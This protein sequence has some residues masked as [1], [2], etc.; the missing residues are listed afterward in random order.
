MSKTTDNV[1][2]LAGRAQPA[3][4]VAYTL[5]NA[6]PVQCTIIGDEPLFFMSYEADLAADED[7]AFD[8]AFGFDA[9]EQGIAELH[10]KIMQMDRVAE[11]L[12]GSGRTIMSQFQEDADFI[13]QPSA[14]ET[15]DIED[16]KIT[17]RQ[18]RLAA[19]Y[20]DFALR[21]KTKISYSREIVTAVYDRHNNAIL[22]NPDRTPGEQLLLAARELRRLWQHRNGALLHPLMFH[23]EQ[24]ILVNRAQIADLS[25]S[26]VRIAWELQ[27]ANDPAAWERLETSSMADLAH[28]FARESALDFRTLNNGAAQS[29]VFEAWFLSERCRHEDRKLIQQM[30]ADYH[31]Y[32]FEAGQQPQSVTTELVGAL[33]SMPF[34]K[35]Y[36][37]P[38]VTTI[39]QDAIFTEV[40][41]RSNANFLWFIKFERSF[42]ETEHD[43]QGDNSVRHRDITHGDSQ[44]NNK[45]GRIG[46]NEKTANII[47]LPGNGKA[48]SP[49]A[50]KRRVG[51]GG[52]NVI[53]FIPERTP[54]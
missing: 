10:E 11:S 33:G 20:M 23:P 36:L 47:A 19:S 9:I 50:R 16:L 8:E 39:T 27:L 53:S 42:R 30:L 21:F 4:R 26:M 1:T 13:T 46:H 45:D 14:P 6:Q 44:I 35:N 32:V 12:D 5:N 7:A 40:R 52:G 34:G 43:L 3:C 54:S 41:D 18:S 37:A 49:A 51:N 25:V 22:I 2:E 15:S 31:G 48:P 17:L 24:A 29:A 38:F 28:A